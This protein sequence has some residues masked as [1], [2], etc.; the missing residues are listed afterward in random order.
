MRERQG[1]E[2]NERGRPERDMR[3]DRDSR[4]ARERKMGG[5]G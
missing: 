1:Q 5:E 3:H 4:E 2:K